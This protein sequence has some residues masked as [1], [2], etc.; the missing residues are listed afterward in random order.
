MLYTMMNINLEAIK[1][2]SVMVN[3]IAII[4]SSGLTAAIGS[5]IINYFI[6]TRKIRAEVIAKSRIEWIQEVRK[7]TSSYL[8]EVSNYLLCLSKL[9]ETKIQKQEYV[10][11]LVYAVIPNIVEDGDENIYIEEEK[12]LD[13]AY[14]HDNELHIKKIQELII[15]IKETE[16]ETANQMKILLQSIHLLRLF[17]PTNSKDNISHTY[18][19]DRM[20]SIS[21]YLN[22]YS[23][24]SHENKDFKKIY[25]YINIEI[26]DFSEMISDYLKAEWD[27]SK[28]L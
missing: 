17:F 3:P 9:K 27:K 22:L 19:K 7:A 1:S 8:I 6:N 13:P 15:E 21:E 14:E 16:I 12:I 23:K 10:G 26:K 20:T 28:K 5:G 11:K 24:I 4:L 25:Q 18:I 2:S